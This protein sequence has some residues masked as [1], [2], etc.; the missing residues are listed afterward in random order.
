MSYSRAQ[1]WQMQLKTLAKYGI[2]EEEH[3]RSPAAL[4]ARDRNFRYWWY[5]NVGSNQEITWRGRKTTIMAEIR[6][7]PNLHL[8]AQQEAPMW[9]A[10]H[11]TT[12]SPWDQSDYD[13][14]AI[15]DFIN[16][17]GNYY[18]CYRYSRS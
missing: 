14:A 17:I 16:Q 15:N 18:I 8:L 13:D 6:S 4:M 3:N 12:D 5:N 7:N 11:L 1:K 2:S 9:Y 10:T